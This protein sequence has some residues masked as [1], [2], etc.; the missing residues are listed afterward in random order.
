MPIFTLAPTH[1]PMS[2]FVNISKVEEDLMDLWNVVSKDEND[3]AQSDTATSETAQKS[4]ITLDS[5]E[6]KT[7]TETGITEKDE[8]FVQHTRDLFDEGV[9]DKMRGVFWAKDTLTMTPEGLE[10]AKFMFFKRW[11]ALGNSFESCGYT[12]THLTFG[13]GPKCKGS[14]KSKRSASLLRLRVR[15]SGKKPSPTLQKLADATRRAIVRRGG[16][17]P[18]EEE[19]IYR[20]AKERN[21]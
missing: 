12:E 7:K 18:K 17:V 5:P 16:K 1:Y 8:L 4:G 9:F 2:S 14:G 11:R 19:F 21:M 20:F 3:D 10:R 6:T 15:R 13:D